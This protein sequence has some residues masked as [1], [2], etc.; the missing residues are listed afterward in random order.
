MECSHFEIKNRD[1]WVCPKCECTYIKKD[2]FKRVDKLHKSGE[3]YSF[4][5]NTLQDIEQIGQVNLRI[6]KGK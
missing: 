1:F 3:K 5:V 6:N 2:L 4:R